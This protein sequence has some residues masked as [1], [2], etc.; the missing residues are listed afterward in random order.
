MGKRIV[1]TIYKSSNIGELVRN[2]DTARGGWHIPPFLTR[3]EK[4]I[5]KKA[6]GNLLEGYSMDREIDAVFIY[7]LL[8]LSLAEMCGLHNHHPNELRRWTWPHRILVEMTLEDTRLN[9]IRENMLI[10]LEW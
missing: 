6:Q 7:E 3:D 9:L 10:L 2:L 4:A 1:T 8:Q 5:L